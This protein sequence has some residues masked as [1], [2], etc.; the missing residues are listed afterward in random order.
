MRVVLTRIAVI[1]V[2]GCVLVYGTDFAVLL[3]RTAQYGSVRVSVMYA[4]KMKNRQTTY[5][6][7]EPQDL[8][9]VNSM[10]PQKGYAPCWYLTRHRQQTVE[11]DAGRRD[12]LLHTP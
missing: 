4:V 8:S 11:I 6:P 1:V 9:C 10:F 3:T 7:E 2:L 12:M 5:L